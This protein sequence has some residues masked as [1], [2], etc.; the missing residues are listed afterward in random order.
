MNTTNQ[1]RSQWLEERRQG[2]GGSDAAAA[3]GL[4]PWKTR[5]EL[6]LEKTGQT[7][8]REETPEMRRGTLLEPVVKQLYADATGRRKGS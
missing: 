2:I 5:L 3:V 4:S 1:D 8:D 6:W 7:P